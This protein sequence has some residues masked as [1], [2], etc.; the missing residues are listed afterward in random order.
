MPRAVYGLV[1]TFVYRFLTGL[2]KLLVATFA[3]WE[4]EGLERLLGQRCRVLAHDAH[5]DYATT[6]LYA[7]R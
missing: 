3:H 6:A 4:I 2:T 5:P 7:P 1:S